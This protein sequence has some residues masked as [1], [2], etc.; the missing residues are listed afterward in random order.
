[1]ANL[2]ILSTKILREVENLTERYDFSASARVSFLA[3]SENKCYLVNDPLRS[4]N[5]VIRL[6][7]G[8]LGHHRPHSIASEMMWLILSLIH[9]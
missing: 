6:N 5:Y 3:E 8:R 4:S 1:M 2:E 9:I 7:S